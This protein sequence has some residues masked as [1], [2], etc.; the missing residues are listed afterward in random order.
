MRISR[1]FSKFS[2]TLALLHGFLIGAVS[3]GLFALLIQWQDIRKVDT[4]ELVTPEEEVPVV[5][6]N[7]DDKAVFPF[8]AKQY[9]VFSTADA[10]ANLIQTN[11]AL[12]SS[13]VIL[14]EDKYYVWSA[15][16]VVEAE[17]KTAESKDSFVKPFQLSASGCKEE[18]LKNIPLLLSETDRA[19]FYFEG[20]EASVKIPDDWKTNIAAISTLSKEINVVR[21]QLLSHYGTQNQ[22]LK[23]QF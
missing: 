18:H 13:A 12:G 10:A 6:P 8:F 7:D 23:I 4:P 1:T 5:A 17:V 3:I 2:Y 22:C 14:A 21:A 20:V 15:V 16:S 11:P 19:K 9:G